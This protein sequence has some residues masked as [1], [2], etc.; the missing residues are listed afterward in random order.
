MVGMKGPEGWWGWLAVLQSGGEAARAP[1]SS[2]P[3]LSLSG[4][5][6][7]YNQTDLYP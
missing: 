7:K 3:P 6:Y 1:A 5:T 2:S 4:N